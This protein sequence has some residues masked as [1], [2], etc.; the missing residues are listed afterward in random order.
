[1]TGNDLYDSSY[2]NMLDK[3][4]VYCWYLYGKKTFSTWPTSSNGV[5]CWNCAHSFKGVPISLPQKRNA[6]GQ[7]F[8]K[9]IFCSPGCAKRYILDEG[10]SFNT[11]NHLAL[12]KMFLRDI[13]GIVSGITAAPPKLLLSK[14]GGPMSIQ[15]YRAYAQDSPVAVE[16]QEIRESAVLESP[17]VSWPTIIKSSVLLGVKNERQMLPIMRSIATYEN[18]NGR[19]PTTTLTT[20]M[21]TTASVYNG[22]YAS[23]LQKNHDNQRRHPKRKRGSHKMLL[24]SSVASTGDT[25]VGSLATFLTAE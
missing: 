17:F 24:R 11:T 13:L 1:M 16:G 12:L 7:W 6:A 3:S 9:G 19:T 15:K 10:I 22:L 4:Y 14:F 18:E 23:W 25:R 8:L 5:S 20:A 2:R 21:T